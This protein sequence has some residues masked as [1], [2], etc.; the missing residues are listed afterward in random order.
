MDEDKAKSKQLEKNREKLIR[1]R[2]PIHSKVPSELFYKNFNKT[3]GNKNKGHI[4]L[5]CCEC[6]KCKLRRLVD[7]GINYKKIIRKINKDN[8]KYW[9]NRLYW[10]RDKMTDGTRII[11][12]VNR[13]EF[14]KEK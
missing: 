11:Q 2:V 14:L 6:I 4:N 5:A 13:K 12:T 9:E 7:N 10:D 1:E 3:F 8:K